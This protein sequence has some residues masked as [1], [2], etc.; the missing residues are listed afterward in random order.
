MSDQH[1]VY[2]ECK[3]GETCGIRVHL[4]GDE[5]ENIYSHTR[6]ENSD[7]TVGLTGMV[8]RIM[9]SSIEG[10]ARIDDSSVDSAFSA[11][12]AKLPLVHREV[13]GYRACEGVSNVVIDSAVN[14]PSRLCFTGR[15]N[16]EKQG[17]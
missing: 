2:R 6:E 12:F 7:D 9:P 16:S 15:E 1:I 11:G 13:Y 3:V 14:E 10:P 17:T 5:V 8:C 4:V